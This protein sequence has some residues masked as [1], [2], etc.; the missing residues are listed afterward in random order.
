MFFKEIVLKLLEGE[1]DANNGD[2]IIIDADLW[3]EVYDI[4]VLLGKLYGNDSSIDVLRKLC[5]Y[6]KEHE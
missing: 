2:K 4:M 5:E 3:S 1:L 6:R